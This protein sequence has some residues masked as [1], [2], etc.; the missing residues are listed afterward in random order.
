MV[1]PQD[2]YAA[3]RR[4]RTSRTVEDRLK[5]SD[6]YLDRY[7]AGRW[8]GDVRPWF[9][10]AEI[11]FFVHH[12]ENASGLEKYLEV[13]PHGPHAV[14]ARK[15]LARHRTR[16]VEGQKSRLEVDARYTE[17]R[18]AAL[19]RMREN[20]RD[21][22]GA[23]VGR[24][25]SIDSWG[26]RTSRLDHEFIYAWRIDKPS[27]RCVEDHCT[28]LVELPFELPGGGD[29]AARE[30]DFEVVLSLRQGMVQEGSLQ[31]PGMF[32]RLYEA[33]RSKPVA[34]GDTGARVQAIAFAV[35]FLSGA[36]EA[37]LPAAKCAADPVGETVMKRAC[38]GWTLEAVAPG[39]PASDDRIVVRGPEKP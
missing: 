24:L 2:E 3:Y 8:I 33:V 4:V 10:R 36:V 25:L 5:A 35:E 11:K 22:L 31:G 7:P 14:L 37:R 30:M 6:W 32:S 9:E 26:E 28:K 17:A 16:V 34:A 27:G 20:T 19:A 21:T 18:L 38:D 15:E 1:A 13:L 29:Q 23:W 12:E 39:D